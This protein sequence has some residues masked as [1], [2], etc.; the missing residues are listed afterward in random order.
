MK[1]VFFG[2]G[3]RGLSCLEALTEAGYRMELAVAHPGGEESWYGSVAGK[4]KGLGIPLLQPEDPNAPEA[5][6]A[7]RAADADLFILAGYGKILRADLIGIPRIMCINL[8]GGKVPRYRGS[9]PLNWALIAGDRSFSLS[10]LKVDA[11][12]D[13]G[14][15]LVQRTFPIAP[16][17]T[18]R[19]LHATANGQFPSMLLEAVRLIEAGKRDF[20]A[21]DPKEAGYYPLRFPDDGFIL[22]DMLTAEQ[23]LNRIRA[24]TEPYPCAFT[25]LGGRRVKLVSAR[26]ARGGFFGE[27]GR[28]YRIAG[29]S[30]LVSASDRCL[31]L[32]RAVVEPDGAELA[33][34]ARRY[35]SL[36]TVRGMALEFYRAGK[37]V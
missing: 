15:V 28:I 13:S 32:D 10:V 6:A 34:V 23:V 35:E 4:A 12:V 8:H 24:L 27:P 29:N 18:I 1:Y 19:D 25:Y 16:T 11:G 2:N 26:P 9:S 5:L 30:A 7:L 22:W 31:W 36:A 21:Q 17:D 37:G 20:P 14:E 3:N 33:S